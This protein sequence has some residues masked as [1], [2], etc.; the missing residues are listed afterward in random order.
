MQEFV[1]FNTLQDFHALSPRR[2]RE[3][4]CN[5]IGVGETGFGLVADQ[6]G[7]VKAGDRQQIAG[8]PGIEL[9]HRNAF[10]TLAFQG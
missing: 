7:I 2:A 4:G 8:L 1:H 3:A 10:G 6:C 9:L 5:Q